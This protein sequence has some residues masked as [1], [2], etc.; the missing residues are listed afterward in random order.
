MC[1]ASGC[2]VRVEPGLRGGRA[3]ANVLVRSALLRRP[4]LGGR[5]LDVGPTGPGSRSRRSLAELGLRALLS[6]ALTWRGRLARRGPARRR[7][8][9]RRR[10]PPTTAATASFAAFSAAFDRSAALRGLL[11]RQTGA[12]VVDRD[13]D[14]LHPRH[15]RLLL[16]GAFLLLQVVVH[17]RRLVA[18][19]GHRLRLGVLRAV[20]RCGVLDLLLVVLRASFS[21]VP[22]PRPTRSAAATR[23]ASGTASP[24]HRCCRGCS[25][26]SCRASPRRPTCPSCPTWRPPGPVPPASSSTTPSTAR[27]ASRTPPPAPPRAVGARRTSSRPEP[28]VLLRV[29][30]VA[31]AGVRGTA[32]GDEHHRDGGR[33]DKD[34]GESLPAARCTGRCMVPSLMTLVVRANVGSLRTGRVRG[35]TVRGDGTAR[36]PFGLSREGETASAG[37]LY[38]RAFRPADAASFRALSCISLLSGRPPMSSAAPRTRSSR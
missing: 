33:A 8:R 28:A 6:D 27:E 2:P 29:V 10:W 16:E 19:A 38:R 18:R 3:P 36:S 15:D 11:S 26:S 4:D 34:A 23:S 22:R 14:V 31:V 13:D 37:A 35:A 20:H 25:R 9:R 32:G 5:L 24:S 1:A 21:P 7:P 17:H 12:V 30:A